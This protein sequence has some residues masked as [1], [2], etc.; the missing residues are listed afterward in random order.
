MM[1]IIISVDEAAILSHYMPGAAMGKRLCLQRGIS[2]GQSAYPNNMEIVLGEQRRRFIDW[3]MNIF[4]RKAD[5]RKRNITAIGKWF[6][7]L[8]A[9]LVLIQRKTKRE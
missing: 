5:K 6:R 9:L 3:T 8:S 2:C 7:F 4:G 1:I